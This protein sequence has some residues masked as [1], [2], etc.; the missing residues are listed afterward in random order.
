MARLS[1]A[2]V[3]AGLFGFMVFERLSLAEL[4]P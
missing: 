3:W 1:W 2:D 4:P